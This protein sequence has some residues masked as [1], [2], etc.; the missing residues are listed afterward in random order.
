VFLKAQ[1][2]LWSLDHLPHVARAGS[3]GNG[4][5]NNTRGKRGTDKVILVPPGTSVSVVSGGDHSSPD[6]LRYTIPS[7]EHNAADGMAHVVALQHENKDEE[8]DYFDHDP[9]EVNGS[10][11]PDDDF[12]RSTEEETTDLMTLIGRMDAL[13]ASR[14]A[15]PQNNYH[16]GSLD[17][18]GQEIL[19]KSI[20]Y[21]YI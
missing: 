17:T 6:L 9:L 16:V 3:G 2:D 11:D 1:N 21:I 19:G 12:I 14:A 5:R 18:E 4:G 15:A 10:S 20:R 7:L 13:D 8:E